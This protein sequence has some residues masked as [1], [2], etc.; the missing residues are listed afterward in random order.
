MSFQPSVLIRTQAALD[1]ATAN[2]LIK[3]DR[4]GFSH[5]FA[6][7]FEAGR[8]MPWF[9]AMGRFGKKAQISAFRVR[10]GYDNLIVSIRTAQRQI[11]AW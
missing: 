10:I 4:P 8:L 7:R 5:D 1:I 6:N 2:K 11:D 9:A 3:T